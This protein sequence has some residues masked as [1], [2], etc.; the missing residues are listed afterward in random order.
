VQADGIGPVGGTSRKYSGQSRIST[1]IHFERRAPGFV[2]PCENPNVLSRV[3]PIESFDKLCVDF[4]LRLRCV[5][6]GLPWSPGTLRQRGMYPPDRRKVKTRCRHSNRMAPPRNGWA[7]CEPFKRPTGLKRSRDRR[8]RFVTWAGWV[9]YGGT[10]GAGLLLPAAI[11][12]FQRENES[13]ADL[14]AVKI[15]SS[16]Y[17]G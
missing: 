1:R 3:N 2:Q 8:E 6:P 15:A 16:A 13:E 17:G 12:K 4:E 9:G 5:L 11:V 10:P 7:L 14:V